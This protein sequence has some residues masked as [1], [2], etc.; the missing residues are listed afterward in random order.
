MKKFVSL[1]LATVMLFT[2]A[3]VLAVDSPQ[4]DYPQKFWDVSKEHWAFPYIAELVNKGVLAGYEDGSF[5]PDRT[6]SRAEWAKI[7][8]LAAGLPTTDTNVYFTDMG[9]HWAN[10]Y[11]N[12]AKDYLAAYSDGTFKPNQ[13]A[14]REDVTVSMVKLKGYDVN[15]VDYSYLSRFSDLNSISNSLK[16]YV[17]VAV[18]KELISGFDDGTFRGQN[19]LT[20]AEAATLLWRAFQYGNDNKVV[21]VPTTPIAET[22]KHVAATENTTCI[23]DP[24]E[25]SETTEIESTEKESE[26]VMEK[27]K[28]KPYVIDTLKQVELETDFTYDGEKIYY[29]SGTNVYSLDPYTGKSKVIYSTED[30]VLQKTETQEKEV[31]KTITVPVEDIEEDAETETE[32]ISEKATENTVENNVDKPK[33][34]TKEITE[35]VTEEVVVE[36]Y[37]NY[38]PTQVK[39]DSYNDRLIMTGYYKN[40]EKAFQTPNSDAKYYVT[41]DITNDEIFWGSGEY[42]SF[43][44]FLSKNK[45]VCNKNGYSILNVEEKTIS[46][47]EEWYGGMH[48]TRKYWVL[49]KDLYKTDRGSGL[50]KYNFSDG[51]F[52][53]LFGFSGYSDGSGG[54]D[55]CLGVNGE[56]VYY[57]YEGAVNKLNLSSGKASELSIT[58]DSEYCD[59]LDMTKVSVYN[60]QYEFIPVSDTHFVFYD[61]AAKAFR[62]LSKR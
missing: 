6:V 18:R 15:D 25:K 22:E 10:I 47:L 20:R 62:T 61:E 43:Y 52:E 48:T 51:C 13:A 46:K 45:A 38:V 21:D 41:Y 42:I 2:S 56:N 9:N 28:E 30:L 12:T 57:W 58:T 32:D 37:S 26:E 49:G 53:R 60:F 44:C 14:V 23:S 1:L 5:R 8:V 50:Y 29:I 16:V 4:K 36:E 7:M 33:E 54:L 3:G 11:I 24:T 35:I 27:P 17:A 40:H 34:I 59:V 19:T 39:Y 55:Y 31:T